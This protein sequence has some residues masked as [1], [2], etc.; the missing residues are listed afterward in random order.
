VYLDTSTSAL[1]TPTLQPIPAAVLIGSDRDLRYAFDLPRTTTVIV[2]AIVYPGW[3]LSLDGHRVPFD[4]FNVG[5]TRV[6]PEVTIGPGHHT[7]EYSWS[8]WP[9]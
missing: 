7:V 9:S 5:R 2:S 4:T 6:F 3:R 1:N 8:G